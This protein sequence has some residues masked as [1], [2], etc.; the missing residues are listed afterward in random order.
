MTVVVWTVNSG[1]V[2]HHAAP[3]GA[4]LITMDDVVGVRRA[5]RRPRRDNR[6]L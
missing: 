3:C 6:K 5:R 4:D 1:P 2:A